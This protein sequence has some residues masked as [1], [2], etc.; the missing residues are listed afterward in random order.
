VSGQ[1]KPSFYNVAFRVDDST[2]FVL[3]NTFSRGLVLVDEAVA[4]HLV[5]AQEARLQLEA[6]L[7]EDELDMLIQSG[8][9]VPY[10]LDEAARFRYAMN[11]QK[12]RSALVPLF[13]SLTSNCNFSCPYCYEDARTSLRQQ[14]D[15]TLE[16]WQTFHR[17]FRRHVEEESASLIIAALYGGEPLLN[18]EVTLQAAKDLYELTSNDRKVAITLI[19]NGSL[20]TVDRVEELAPLLNSVQITLDGPPEIHNLTRPYK[21]GIKESYEDV[22]Q[23]IRRCVEAATLETILRVNISTDTA[24]KV[25]LLLQELSGELTF[26]H[27]LTLSLAP[28]HGSQQDMHCGSGRNLDLSLLQRIAALYLE[29]ARLGYRLGQNFI[30]GPCMVS[31]ANSMTVDENLD[32]YRCPGRIYERPDA[33]I[34]SDGT[35]DIL[36]NEWYTYVDFEPS[37][38]LSC[39]YAPICYGGCRWKAGGEAAI[40]CPKPWF[41]EAMEDLVLAYLHAQHGEHLAT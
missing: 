7:D 4:D 38:V 37:C 27:R 33:H 25:S 41:E 5:N 17:F 3:F 1:L 10:V 29:A 39:K 22:L 20:L 14:A 12:Y 15:M 13:I 30:P 11:R 16:T 28:V 9:L 32:L 31:F 6:D 34:T 40:V 23:S 36:R 35:V 21:D 24:E 19:T 26:G 2:D 18:Y 8:I